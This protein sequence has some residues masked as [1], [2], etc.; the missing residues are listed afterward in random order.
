[1]NFR[2][3]GPSTV[4]VFLAAF[5]VQGAFGSII[6]STD[7]TGR[8]LAGTTASNI[9]WTTEGIQNPGDLTF[10]FTA[11]AG[12]T[13]TPES[14]LQ[15]HDTTASA[16]H[17][18]PNINVEN[19]GSWD[20]DIPLAFQPNTASLS[21]DTLVIDWQ[22]FNNSGSFQNINRN[23]TWT[24]TVTGSS[25][26]QVAAPSVIF[27]SGTGTPATVNFGGLGLGNS[28]SWTLNIS[29]SSPDFPTN[30]NN[31]GFD[32]VTLNGVVFVPEPSSV[33]GL[34]VLVLAASG[35]R[36]RRNMVR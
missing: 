4:V 15:F 20:V 11:G 35:R 2:I 7:F 8:T 5:L 32:A 27:D 29:V 33:L 16:G 28:E 25:S 9:T 23:L 22:H 30:G 18:A 10:S 31:V 1:M 17:F 14:P 19:E 6:L 26:G 13:S 36:R 24:A 34:I 21:L 12:A 3:V